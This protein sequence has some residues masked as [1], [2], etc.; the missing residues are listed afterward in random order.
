MN[1]G[2]LGPS[3]GVVGISRRASSACGLGG[4]VASTGLRD[5][6]R[7]RRR[8]RVAGG[9]VFAAFG[10][11]AVGLVLFSLRLEVARRF[12][13]VRTFGN[14]DFVGGRGLGTRQVLC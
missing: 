11:V 6:R 9:R 13:L 12:V 1:S 3:G 7:R 4:S 10:V 14:G 8:R 5:F 2:T